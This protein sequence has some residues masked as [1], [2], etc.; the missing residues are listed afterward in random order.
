MYLNRYYLLDIAR[1]LAAFVVVIFH[2]N[3]FY[4]IETSKTVFK[5]ENQ[6]FYHFFYYCYEFGWIAVQF[7]FIISGFIFYALYSKQISERKISKFEFFKLR[8]SRLYP[9]HFITL[10]I[11]VILLYFSN[12]VSFN[13]PINGD[14]KHFF[15]NIFLIH[16]W[17]FESTHSFNQPSWSI[18]IEALLYLVFFIVFYFGKNNY[19]ITIILLILSVP[20]FFLNKFIGYG[21]FC[22]YMGGLT[23]LIYQKIIESK[24][25]IKFMYFLSLI[26]V[27]LSIIIFNYLNSS[28]IIKIVTFTLFFPSIIINLM[29]IQTKFTGIGKSFKIIGDISYSV[30]LTHWVIQALI[31]LLIFN[32]KT[33]I[34]FN[35]NYVFLVYLMTVCLISLISFK[36]FERP[37]QKYIRSN[38]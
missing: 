31:S 23:Y 21:F 19:S 7:F 11:T 16:K 26:L 22:F 25:R 17:G 38:F 34:D 2:Y 10:I 13:Q 37:I 15:L 1:G 33:K 8:F 24:N 3:I 30:Y 20:L 14:V 32:Y 9:L 36:F 12:K 5:T 18:S 6:P 29:M 35:S 28:V 4:N 27:F